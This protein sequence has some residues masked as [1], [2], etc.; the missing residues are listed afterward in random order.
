V[1]YAVRFTP[2]GG[3]VYL[4][5]IEDRAVLGRML[6]VI[7]K[8]PEIDTDIAREKLEARLLKDAADYIESCRAALADAGVSIRTEPIVTTGHHLP[9]YER[10]IEEHHIDL[11]VMNTR[12]DD[13]MAMHGLAYSLAIE[14]RSI[15]LL[16][17]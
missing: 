11:L 15:P 12:D 16:M 13:Q 17:L 2:R 4:A 6:D 9:E 3:T 5:H 1:N 10:L 8:I 7:G 14:L